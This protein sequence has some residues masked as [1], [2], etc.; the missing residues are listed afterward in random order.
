MLVEPG[1]SF[2]VLKPYLVW[3]GA[4]ML[5]SGATFLLSM[6]LTRGA[7]LIRAA[8]LAV[9]AELLA[10][11]GTQVTIRFLVNFV[12]LGMLAV[13]TL[14]AAFLVRRA[15]PSD[16]R[17][18]VDLFVVVAGA[19]TAACGVMLVTVS[20]AYARASNVDLGVLEPW[21]ALGLIGAGSGLMI[22]ELG[23]VAPVRGR[24]LACAVVGGALWSFVLLVA[25]PARSAIGSLYLG[26]AGLLIVFMPWAGRRLRR[27]SH[28]SLRTRFAILLAGVTALALVVTIALD[29]GIDNSAL[30]DTVL[31]QQ[32]L[33]A[34]TVA[35]E[36]ADS[37]AVPGAV[38]P[39]RIIA[40][41]RRS[42]VSAGQEIYLVDAQGQAVGATDATP[43]PLVRAIRS[44]S[45]AGTLRYSGEGGE[46]LA[47]FAPVGELGWWIIVDHPALD[48]LAGT[49][50][51]AD[52]R[53]GLLAIA[54]AALVGALAAGPLASVAVR[55]ANRN[56]AALIR[57]SPVAVIGLGRDGAVQEWNPAAEQMLGLKRADVVGQ[58]LGSV[59][60]DEQ[61]R[62]V[63]MVELLPGSTFNG[64]ELRVRARSQKLIDVAV[65]SAPLHT[66]QGDLDGSLVMLADV[67]ERKRLDV[68]RTRRLRE[69]SQ[70]TEM[71]TVLDRLAFLADATRDISSSLDL[72]DTLRRAASVA[73]PK[74]AD[75]CTLQL[76]SPD[77][78][79]ETVVRAVADPSLEST[80]NE[81][82][83]RYPPEPG[84][85]AP[86]A[87]ALRSGM[88]VLVADVTHEWLENTAV[89]DAHLRYLERLAPR[90]IMSI[91]LIARDKI[92]GAMT[93]ASVAPSRSYNA[94]SLALAEALARRCALAI[95]NA[96]LHR[97]TR[98]AL[99]A[100]DTFLSVASHEL[101][102]PLA[103]L[104]VHTE[105]L[106]LAQARH[107]LDDA[108]L[109]RSLGSIQRAIN[110]LTTITQDLLD[111]ARWR[112]GDI[113]IRP[114]RLDVGKHI[115]QL[116]ASYRDRIEDGHR[117]V[118]RVARGHHVVLVDITRFEQVVE[119]L[120]DNAFKY[121]PDGG[122]IQVRVRSEGGGVLVSVQDSGI[123]LPS[124]VADAIFEPFGRAPNAEQRSVAGM[125]LGLYI[126][127]SIVERHG[128]RIWA[129]SRGESKGTTMNV[130]LPGAPA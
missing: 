11:A 19:T 4:L 89:D 124:G 103:R 59:L 78:R 119:N 21:Y 91:P 6:T 65:W 74:L 87:R 64:V 53:I 56:F 122:D 50:Q 16:G 39:T 32:Q 113:A 31:N 18:H 23:G 1:Q 104:R 49:E 102:S 36:I 20:G 76:V 82:Q 13:G 116:V 3:A 40:A 99:R 123:G 69:Q 93:F 130:W 15:R 66:E 77:G 63:R 38:D 41:V 110:R 101:G 48:S 60:R 57:G 7:P 24:T 61:G 17:D 117:L 97:E 45:A 54:A 125:G 128:G 106:I 58:E 73:V 44:A 109:K 46:W 71:D 120:L 81:I 55:E 35:A 98:D 105:V 83:Q 94:A 8:H 22:L 33:V 95:D 62:P 43:D 70:L 14:A 92:V 9:G 25:A 67:S 2:G 29:V 68:E 90:S 107:A 85:L 34:M 79:I 5:I 108:L 100:R 115:R 86:S 12:S 72:D 47:G 51:I 30:T 114:S 111:V 88:P 52:Y 96:R 84:G 75:W 112:G 37:D 10:L 127:R 42:I 118:V 27:P 129:E 121:S 26:P 28:L 80:L 126:C